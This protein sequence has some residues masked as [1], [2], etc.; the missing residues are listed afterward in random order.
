MWLLR[1]VHVPFIGVLQRQSFGQ[2]SALTTQCLMNQDFKS[3]NSRG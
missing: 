1:I 2:R 3:N